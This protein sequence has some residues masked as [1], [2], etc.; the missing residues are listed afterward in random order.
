MRSEAAY[1]RRTAADAGVMSALI[2]DMKEMVNLNHYKI[3]WRWLKFMYI[4]TT[5]IAGGIGLAQLL[6]PSQMQSTL[7]MPAQDPLVFGL[8]ASVFLALGLVAILGIRAPLKYCSILLVELSY[9][10]LWLCGVVVPL[11]LR[12]EFP[13]SSIVQVA[14][15][16]TFVVGDLIA[17][18]F[19]YL[20][21]R[22]IGAA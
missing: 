11:A 13:N 16:C 2:G 18:P 9:K 7:G 17:I 3:R 22:D 14:I 5:V 20:F 8:G 12:G 21:S 1:R 10:L 6:A 15:F 19:R 4:Y